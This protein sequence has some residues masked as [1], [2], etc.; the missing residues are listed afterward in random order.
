M[1]DSRK[2][3]KIVLSLGGG[4]AKTFAH[5]G[6]FDAFKKHNLAIDYLV[7]CSAASVVSVLYGSG[8]TSDEIKKEFKRKRKWLYIARR[9][10]FSR[11]LQKCIKQKELKDIKDLK[12]PISIISVDLKTGREIIFEEGDP[13]LIP[14]G[15]SAFPG[16]WQP[17]KYKNYE[18]IDGGILNPDPANIA[19]SKVGPKGVVISVTLKMDFTE[20][21]SKG[22]FRTVLRSLYLLPTRYRSKIIKN[23]SDIII[24]PVNGLKVSFHD[25]RETFVGYFSNAKIDD[26]YNKGFAE[27]EKNIIKIKNLLKNKR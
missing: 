17:I 3:P 18:L 4:G 26:Y 6:V 7:T 22:R 11:V 13:L 16:I 27:T 12:I 19:R 8:M 10:I 1:Q 24:T 2:V 15:S 5:L 23:N 14:L 21:S 9:S 20:D 25:W